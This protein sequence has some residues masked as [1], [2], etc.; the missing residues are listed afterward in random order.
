MRCS[1]LWIGLITRNKEKIFLSLI[2]FDN[3]K[4]N[5]HEFKPTIPHGSDCRKS[6]RKI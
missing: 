6:N 2:I 4:I 3:K 5:N 1:Y